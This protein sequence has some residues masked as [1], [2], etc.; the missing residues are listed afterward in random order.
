MPLTVKT[1]L[2]KLRI[3]KK[4]GAQ[5]VVVNFE[6][7]IVARRVFSDLALHGLQR[8]GRHPAQADHHGIVQHIIVRGTELL[9]I[10]E[11]MEHDGSTS[12]VATTVL[13]SFTTPTIV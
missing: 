3:S 4:D 12:P 1:I 8:L 9:E 5:F 13:K 2:R 6:R 11:R 10:A 7:M